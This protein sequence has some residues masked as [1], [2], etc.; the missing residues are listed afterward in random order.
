MNNIQKNLFSGILFGIVGIVI[1]AI[2]N[3]DLDSFIA[4]FILCI[5]QG[6]FNDNIKLYKQS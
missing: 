5:L 3:L 1:V 6:I 2:C 4:G